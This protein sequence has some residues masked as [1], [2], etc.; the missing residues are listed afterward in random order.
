MASEIDTGPPPPLEDMSHVL[1]QQLHPGSRLTSPPPS[2][3]DD[4]LV[5]TVLPARTDEQS[6]TKARVSTSKKVSSAS[7]GCFGGLK[8][9]F[10]SASPPSST[11]TKAH[12]TVS[13]E[14]QMPFLQKNSQ[15]NSLHLP[16]VEQAMKQT[17][18]SFDNKGNHFSEFGGD[19]SQHDAPSQSPQPQPQPQPQP[20]DEDM[21]QMQQILADAEVREILMDTDI[22][23]LLTC[24]KTDPQQAQRFV[25]HGGSDM[26]AKINKLIKAGLLQMEPV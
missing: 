25:H 17:H 12:R 13:E 4:K 15:T 1:Q 22:Q 18:S 11:H 24:L 7:S 6:R 5:D 3:H 23:T 2:S 16:E 20:C 21:Q 26:K 19:G 8:K 9:G 14:D 10:L